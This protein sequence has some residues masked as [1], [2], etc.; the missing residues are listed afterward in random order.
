MENCMLYPAYVLVDREPILICF[1]VD[2]SLVVAGAGVSVKVPR[3]FYEGVHCVGVPPSRLSAFRTL[4]FHP[5]LEVRQRRPSVLGKI[6]V[7][8]EHYR[9]T[10]IRYRHYS[11]VRAMNDRNWR[12]PVSLSGDSPI[13]NTVI[14]RQP[15]FAHSLEFLSDLL[16]G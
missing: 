1:G 16:L 2:Y 3:G 11:A 10:L 15:T 8:R 9:E 7:C 4:D 13:T 5:P 12:P 14:N 6:N